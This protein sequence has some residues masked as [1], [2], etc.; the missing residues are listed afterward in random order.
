MKLK[1]IISGQCF[2]GEKENKLMAICVKLEHDWMRKVILKT[3]DNRAV[4][5]HNGKC[6]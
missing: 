5:R 2:V 3:M 1:E 4:M 6:C